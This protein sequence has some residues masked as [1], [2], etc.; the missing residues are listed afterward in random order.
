M[1]PYFWRYLDIDNQVIEQTNFAI[2]RER[3][4]AENCKR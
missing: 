1:F 3:V 2:Q 4:A